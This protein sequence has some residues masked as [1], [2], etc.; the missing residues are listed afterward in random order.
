MKRL[1]APL[2]A[3]LILPGCQSASRT[4]A[5][6]Q[7]AERALE[8]ATAPP[9]AS[10]SVS[11]LA[12]LDELSLPVSDH[13]SAVRYCAFMLSHIAVDQSVLEIARQRADWQKI[14]GPRPAISGFDFGSLFPVIQ[15]EPSF[16]HQAGGK[17]GSD[18]RTFLEP[19]VG[20]CTILTTGEP[21]AQQK[22]SDWLR[23]KDS[24]WVAA[25]RSGAWRAYKL[26]NPVHITQVDVRIFEPVLS[27]EAKNSG[28]T[29]LHVV[30]MTG[31][32]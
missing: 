32:P 2:S 21:A 18:S 13:L 14:N 9:P 10:F 22:T 16:S 17:P 26:R 30:A 11:A 12:E 15:T 8:E 6:I 7:A 25:G 24:S 19:N 1:V 3:L 4:D 28:V 23:A 29:G 5:Y 31:L 20:V 27:A